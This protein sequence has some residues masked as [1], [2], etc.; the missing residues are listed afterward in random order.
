MYSS[1]VV[2]LIVGVILGGACLMCV[3]NCCKRS[4]KKRLDLAR[5]KFDIN[6]V[7]QK[8]VE[9]DTNDTRDL[10][11]STSKP[12]EFNG[13]AVLPLHASGRKLSQKDT[14]DYEVASPDDIP[15]S[16]RDRR[17]TQ[18]KQLDTEDIEA[19]A[20]EGGDKVDSFEMNMEAMLSRRALE[21]N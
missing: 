1:V 13:I 18:L 5:Q 8:T 10:E 11:K 7:P 3:M 15:T 4:Q 6:M 21:L 14:F 20:E 17:Q 2:A 12:G 19:A 16:R 9:L